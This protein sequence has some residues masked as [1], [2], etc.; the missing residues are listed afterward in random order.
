MICSMQ[1]FIYK[2]YFFYFIF[3]PDHI[4]SSFNRKRN[5]LAK[6]ERE[7]EGYKNRECVFEGERW[8][9]RENE[10]SRLKRLSLD[11]TSASIGAWK[12]N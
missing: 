11:Q 10:R 5:R 1:Y 7:R 2:T 3:S 8:I 9:D 6:I 4:R 12:Y